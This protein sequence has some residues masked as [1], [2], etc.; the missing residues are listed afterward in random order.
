MVDWGLSGQITGRHRSFL[1]TGASGCMWRRLKVSKCQS[2]FACTFNNTYIIHMLLWLNETEWKS[3][4]LLSCPQRLIFFPC[5]RFNHCTLSKKR[6]VSFSCQL[7]ACIVY[8]KV[9][10]HVDVT[11]LYW[12]STAAMSNVWNERRFETWHCLNCLSFCLNCLSF[13]SLQMDHTEY[14]TGKHTTSSIQQSP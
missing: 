9:Y 13:M 1:Q 6:N 2:F 7:H 4:F 3:A 5:S 12:Y 10:S 11:R 14:D 8:M